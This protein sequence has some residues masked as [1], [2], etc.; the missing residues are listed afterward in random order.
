MTAVHRAVVALVVC[1]SFACNGILGLD[2][3]E[4]RTDATVDDAADGATDGDE[5]NADAGEA[6]DVDAGPDYCA[7][8]G[9]TCDDPSQCLVLYRPFDT[10]QYTAMCGPLE[11]GVCPG[12]FGTG[13]FACKQ[14]GLACAF[15]FEGGSGAARNFCTPICGPGL[16]PCEKPFFCEHT[17]PIGGAPGDTGLCFWCDPFHLSTDECTPEGGECRLKNSLAAPSCEPKRAGT[18]KDGAACD[19][20]KPCAHLYV[21]QCDTG[22]EDDCPT[23]GVCRLLC[24]SPTCA[25]AASSCLLINADSRWGTCR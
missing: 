11:A 5:T 20:T 18:G 12:A 16:P 4:G 9:L 17:Q 23:G 15:S 25:G 13:K 2:E 14:A 3:R 8:L 1:G 7:A 10:Q 24:A 19:A 6:A 21:C 22:I